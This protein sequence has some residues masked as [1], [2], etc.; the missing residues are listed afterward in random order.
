MLLRQGAPQA[1]P[2][3]GLAAHQYYCNPP[4]GLTARKFQ[5]SMKISAR[6]LPASPDGMNSKYLGSRSAAAPMTMLSGLAPI[7]A[8]ALATLSARAA[9]TSKL[10][11]LWRITSIERV[12]E[13][14]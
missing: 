1:G 12:R 5:Y 8:S 4:A 3:A 2:L 10:T 7:L 11:I 9:E 6:R 13:L 14:A